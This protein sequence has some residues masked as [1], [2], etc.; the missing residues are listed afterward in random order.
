MTP[1]PPESS[2]FCK[3]G[4]VVSDTGDMFAVATGFRYTVFATVVLSGALLTTCDVRRCSCREARL[5][6]RLR[7]QSQSPTP[8]KAMKAEIPTP[9]PAP[10]ATL[11]G[12]DSGAG[13][14]TLEPLLSTH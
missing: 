11:F 5:R 13:L 3:V 10:R 7:R 8:T 14:G 6:R 4:E 9:R 1:F 12:A 2:V